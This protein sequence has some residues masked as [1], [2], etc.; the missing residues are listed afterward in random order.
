LAKMIN[1]LNSAEYKER[2]QAQNELAP[3]ADYIRNT[4]TERAKT[5]AAESR[6][7]INQLLKSAD[8][9][10]SFLRVLRSMEVLEGMATPEAGRILQRWTNLPEGS[11]LREEAID[12]LARLN[13]PPG[14]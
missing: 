10:P 11:R 14:E 12:S 3:I 2:E 8:G 5:D 1:R 13:R 7:R 4:L 9:Q 6:E